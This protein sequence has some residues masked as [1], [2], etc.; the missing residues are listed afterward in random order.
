MINLLIKD[1][2]LMFSQNAKKSE[3]ILSAVFVAIFVLC[4]V[5]VELF[6]FTMIINKV[7]TV[8]GGKEAFLSVFLFIITVLMTVSAVFSAKKLFFDPE[9]IEM[10]SN[11]PVK[12]RQII[13][14]KIIIL[15][16][17]ETVSA[18]V[19]V[20]PLFIAYGL[21]DGRTALFYF[22]SLFYPA[23]S[24]LAEA[25]IAL[26]LVYPAYLVSKFLKNRPVIKIIIASVVLGALAYFYSKALELFVNLA[27]GNGMGTLF[28]SENVKKL[29]KFREVVYPVNFLMDIFIEKKI[30]SFFI[31]I[32]I[33][34]IVFA[35]GVTITTLAYN[36]V[37]NVSFTVIRRSGG[38]KLKVRSVI[39]T[40]IRKELSLLFLS[41]ENIFS[42]TGLIIVQPFLLTMVLRAMNAIF[43]SGT[44]AYYT[45]FIPG[46]NAFVDA[47]FVIIFSTTIAGGANRFI[48]TEQ[49]TVKNMKTMPVE[50]KIQLIIKAALPFVVSTVSLLVSVVVLAAAGVISALY[51]VFIF[52]LADFSLALYIAISL[53]EELKIRHG[54]ARKTGLSSAASYCL[55]IAFLIFSAAFSLAGL[56]PVLCFLTGLLIYFALTGFGIYNVYKKSGTLFLGLEAV[57]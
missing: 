50:P 3:K 28:G 6:I 52:L 30:V 13:A 47:F 19:F 37:R 4:F 56:N 42:Y 15:F 29:N 26:L 21:K 41:S 51:A 34:V 53:Y 33:S 43:G 54:V 46:F 45:S 57:N 27:A 11:R 22:T 36:Y 32:V 49:A 20:Y 1:F 14:S 44:M 16:L 39:K 17:T 18:L 7:S 2:K 23:F 31:Y 25:G 40:L 8:A 24:F 38:K 55:P 9:D 5:A 48:S 12:S 10:L 35:V